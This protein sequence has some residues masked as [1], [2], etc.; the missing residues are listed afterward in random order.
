MKDKLKNLWAVLRLPI[1]AVVLGFLVG[2]VCILIAGSNPATAY[3][4]LFR[5]SLGSLPS[6]GETLYKM[7]PILLTG[8]SVAVAFRC[9]LFNIGGEG[10]YIVAAISTVA[11]AWFFQDLPRPILILLLLIVG[12]LAGGIWGGIAG[13]L[14]AK[15][16]INEVITTIMLNWISLYLSNY[17]VRVILN[18]VNLVPGASSAANTVSIPEAARLTKLKDIIPGFGYSSASTSIL[19]ALVMVFIVY[20]F[21]FKTAAGYEIRGVGL[22]PD[23][24]EYGGI[25]KQKNTVLAMFISGGLSGL[26]GTLQII[27]LVFLVN[28]STDLPGYGF[29]GISVAL[30]G[31]NHPI[32]V[33]PA[34]LLFGILENGARQMQLAGIP[35]E[36]TGI[37]QAVI[38][39][40]VAGALV[41][42]ILE[43]RRKKQQ[44]LKQAAKKEVSA[45][46]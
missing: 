1:I 29:T 45:D 44:L 14:K 43:D 39:V 41:I 33:I 46:A 26:A 3:M 24:A 7:T 30:V 22:N 34:A 40:F 9:G 16:Q 31:C 11:A 15:F 10:Q 20:F 38:L 35:K 18:P 27:G 4:A 12:M 37:I 32:G 36:I 21:L 13:F 2:A 8:L 17:I 28:Q 25:S 23:A 42:K 6:I 19:I 5:G